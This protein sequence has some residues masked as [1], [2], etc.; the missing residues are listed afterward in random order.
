MA[1]VKPFMLIV[2]DHDH[3]T[4][5]V[6]GP[7]TDDRPWNSAVCRAQETGREVRCFSANLDISKH[8]PKLGRGMREVPCGSIVHP[9]GI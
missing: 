8:G 9:K 4:Y 6:E 3:K 1:R 2:V 5:S 7:M